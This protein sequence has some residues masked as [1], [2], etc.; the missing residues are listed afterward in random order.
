M[1]VFNQLTVYA[2]VRIY[3]RSEDGIV[4]GG[5]PL[6]LKT[7]KKSKQWPTVLYHVGQ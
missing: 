1:H 5:M 7:S 6:L 2:G 4:F 3:E